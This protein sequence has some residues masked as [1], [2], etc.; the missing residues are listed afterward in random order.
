M[1]RIMAHLVA[2]Y[3]DR[4][5][6]IAVA[7]GLIDGGASYL[8]IQFPF[9][10]P[11]ADGPAIQQACQEALESGFSV[12]DGFSFVHTVAEAA[13]ASGRE[14]PIFLMTYASLIYARGVEQFMRDGESAGVGGF[15]LPDIPVDYDEG[16]WEAAEKTGTRI[17]PVTVTT[18]APERMELIAR[19]KP[20]YTYVALR[21]GITGVKTEVGE[22]NLSV[23]DRMAQT[24]TRVMAGFGISERQQV[25]SLDPHVHACVV[26][27]ALVRTVTER[28]EQA[29][30]T[31]REAV[32]SRLQA[33]L[34]D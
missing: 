17:M 8:E 22:E 34:V 31:I 9:S 32:R 7:Q 5:R 3:P 2:H 20:E 19:K 30:Q 23:L 33:L 21:R 25:R 1:S 27:S 10:D 16:V 6:S 13:E 24:G 4:E 14:V 11:T 12:N 26:G 28:R 15:I 29:P 18:A